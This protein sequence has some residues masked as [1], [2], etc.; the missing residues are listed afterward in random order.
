MQT[1]IKILDSQELIDAA[2]VLLYN[3]Y[4]ENAKSN[5]PKDSP[6]QNQVLIKN[7]KKM[8][9]DQHTN[10]AI[11]FGAF[12]KETLVACIRLIGKDKDNK[13][14]IEYYSG[15]TVI[16]EYI[17]DKHLY[18]DTT[19]IAVHTAFP[20]KKLVILQLFLDIFKYCSSNKYS[21]IALTHDSYL[22]SLFTLINFPLVFKHAF[23]L[24]KIDPMPVDF[25]RACLKDEIK[26]VLSNLK[27]LIDIS[28]KP[29]FPTM[30][31]LFQVIAP[32]IPSPIYWY[33]KD[34]IVL[35]LNQACLEQIGAKKFSDIVGK[36]PYDYF[37]AEI[38]KRI[39]Q[40]NR[41]VMQK[42]TTLSKEES[43]ND[44]ATGQYKVFK[45][46]K[47]P[48]YDEE[49]NVIGVV[50]T[51]VDITAEKEAEQLKLKNQAQ[52]TI[53]EA[54]KEFKKCLDEIQHIIQSYKLNILN[55]LIGV[56]DQSDKSTDN[57]DIDINNIA[58]TK[59]E[60]EILY[61][62]SLNKSPKEI[63]II[64]GTVYKKNVSSATIQSV[65]N[66]KLYTKFNV[67]NVSG[68]I[69]KA[70]KYKLIPFIPDHS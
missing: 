19:S 37:P 10:N 1:N 11:W 43:I 25:Y 24:E 27:R 40:N 69:E 21:V 23:K 59:R 41:Q 7:K 63:S 20:N 46:I 18:I 32:V 6:F 17:P 51:S 62:L 67:F 2:C 29:R 22:K 35:G 31:E 49:G 36:S 66:K 52:Q 8:L 48:L 50:G 42:K 34:N 70:N 53:I 61:Y 45:S 39:V 3:S 26:D 30:L 57:I 14:A 60:I 65:I 38:A 55:N 54:H 12:D 56:K 15:N 28:I 47:Y 16:S 58:L 68:L 64:L 9:I 44:I 13:F 33:D 5:F 4:S